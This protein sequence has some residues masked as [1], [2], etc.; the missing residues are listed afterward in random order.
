MLFADAGQGSKYVTDSSEHDL[1]RQGGQSCT[2]HQTNGARGCRTLSR[3]SVSLLHQ[4][5][6]E[7]LYFETSLFN[8]GGLRFSPGTVQRDG[9]RRDAYALCP[10]SEPAISA[11]EAV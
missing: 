7:N 9:Q 10:A 4:P 5:L 1:R 2:A 3:L 8:T 6:V 11:A